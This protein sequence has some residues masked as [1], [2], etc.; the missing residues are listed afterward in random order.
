[1]MLP[2]TPLASEGG[3]GQEVTTWYCYEY[4]RVIKEQDNEGGTAYNVYGTNLIIRELDGEK[5]YYIY[6]GHGDVTGLLSSNGTVI[7]SYYYDVYNI[8]EQL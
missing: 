4:S 6:N 3:E 7:A 5:V 2:E 8:V 1:M